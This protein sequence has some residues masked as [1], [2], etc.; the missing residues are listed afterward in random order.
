[1][2]P[3]VPWFLP[4]GLQALAM[5]VDEWGWHRTRAVER[6]EWQGHVLDTAVFL[7]CLS[8]PLLFPPAASAL[9]L[10]LGLAGLS[11]LLVTK[12]EWRL[13][14]PVSGGEAW[15]HAVL[16]LLHPLVLLAT[17][18]LWLVKAGAVLAPLPAIPQSLARDGL[19]AQFLL[20]AG[21]LALQAAWGAGRRPRVEPAIDNTLYD[22]LGERWY[23]ARDNPVA[24]LRAEA[25]LR[26]RWLLDEL[27]EG[28]PP[29][30][31]LDVACGAGFLANPL[32]AAGHAVTGVDLSPDS[33]EVGR[34]HDPTGTVTWR[35]MD[36]R[37]LD[38]PDGS[39]D[40]VTMMDFLEHLED[41][42]A[43]IREASRVLKPGGRFY[44]HTFNRT[45]WA[46]LLAIKG[47]AWSV[48]NTPRH[49]HTYALFLRPEELAAICRRHRLEVEVL[50][51][52]KP[53][54][55]S[56]AF[57]WLLAGARVSDGFRFAFTP[58]LGVGYCGRARRN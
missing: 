56:W 35:V 2:S 51:G 29:L 53:V 13:H 36:A 16:F 3:A 14:R 45:P 32:A 39:F 33:L 19:S 23:T 1:V 8:C 50:R 24:L 40:V 15:L 57:L 49:L 47:V 30:A 37:S 46:W 18:G 44:F 43:V 9:W 41:R 7:G 28:G 48:K 31:V 21:F 17:A 58:F 10:Y 42:D 22:R 54:V 26:T 4:V 12:D 11:C 38:F 25:R 55:R 5:A 20:V 34:R 27:G 52:V 6:R